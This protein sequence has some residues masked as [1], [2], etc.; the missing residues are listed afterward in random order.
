MVVYLAIHATVAV[1]AIYPMEE[2]LA[3]HSMEDH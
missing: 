2:V 1:S 3:I